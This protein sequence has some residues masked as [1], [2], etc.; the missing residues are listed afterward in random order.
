M[1]PSKKNLISTINYARTKSRSKEP[2]DL[3]FTIDINNIPPH[4]L[5][6]DIRVGENRHIIFMTASMKSLV[7]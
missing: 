7:R 3:N 1:I 2:V 5:C 4:L 6:D